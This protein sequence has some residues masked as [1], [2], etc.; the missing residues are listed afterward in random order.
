MNM[1]VRCKSPP[2]TI[3][4]NSAVKRI[5][6]S[7]VAIDNSWIDIHTLTHCGAGLA[8]GGDPISYTTAA[9]IANSSELATMS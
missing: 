6:N 8:A 3:D 1:V 5:K 7:V 4:S 2:A 9:T